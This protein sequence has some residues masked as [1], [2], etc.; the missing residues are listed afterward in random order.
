MD[1]ALYY[2]IYKEEID[3]QTNKKYIEY[4]KPSSIYYLIINYV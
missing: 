1:L 3:K 4:V 2:K